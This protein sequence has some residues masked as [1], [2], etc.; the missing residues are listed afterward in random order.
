MFTQ[1]VFSEQ[2]TLEVTQLGWQG[3]W[4]LLA[5]NLSF[6]LLT[7]I[8]LVHWAIDY[9]KVRRTRPQPV[10]VTENQTEL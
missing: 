7:I 8:T 1:P 3:A 2:D 4:F 6:I 5:C 10:V 9:W